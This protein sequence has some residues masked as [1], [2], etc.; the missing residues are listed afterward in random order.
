MDFS[1]KT[2]SR[3]DPLHLDVL[4]ISYLMSIGA[5]CILYNLKVKMVTV[6]EFND[7]FQIKL[8]IVG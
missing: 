3:R 2:S 1:P 4:H 8:P 6:N 5:M 7:V